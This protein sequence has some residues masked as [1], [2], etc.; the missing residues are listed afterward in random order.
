MDLFL[1]CLALSLG[2][3]ACGYRWCRERKHLLFS[4][5]CMTALVRNR[6]ATIN[7]LREKQYKEDKC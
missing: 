1:C 2:W 5:K 3:A 4:L 6:E 7:E